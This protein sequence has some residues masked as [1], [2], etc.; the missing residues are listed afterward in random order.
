MK[1]REVAGP[2]LGESLLASR[3]I[4]VVSPHPDDES[5]GC[6]GMM[7]RAKALGSQVFVIC[8]S[9]PVVL[10][11]F[12]RE[13]PRISGQTRWHEFEDA[14]RVVGV[15]DYCLLYD[16]ERTHMRLDIVARMDLLLKIERDCPL[17]IERIKPDIL[18]FP[19]KSYNQDHEAI[20]GA[21]FAAC[22]PHLRTDKAFVPLLLSYDQPQLCWG[23]EAFQ[24]NFYVD[25]T[26][27]LNVKLQACACHRSQLRTEPHLASLA[28][29][30][31]LA[32]LRGSEVSVAAAEAFECRRL[33]V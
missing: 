9:V 31:R 3:R 19:A 21:V 27:Y 2:G 7:A 5:F 6:A 16:D 10:E 20:F 11:Q 4:L 14:M 12:S 26:D 30:E 13:N 8:V 23:D 33:F 32:R 15:D 24:P 22:R 1:D 25:I 17:S 18:C 29:I 28:N